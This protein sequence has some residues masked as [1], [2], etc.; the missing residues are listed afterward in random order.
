[1]KHAFEAVVVVLSFAIIAFYNLQ[2]TGQQVAGAQINPAVLQ[3]PVMTFN[4]Q[5]S[6]DVIF[7]WQR[8]SSVEEQWLDIS[9]FDNN[10]ADGTFLTANRPPNPASV[11]YRT[12]T[13]DIG[14]LIVCTRHYWRINT[15]IDGNW[16]PSLT[17]I[18]DTPCKCGRPCALGDGVGMH[19]IDDNCIGIKEFYDERMCCI[20]EDCSDNLCYQGVCVLDMLSSIKLSWPVDSRDVECFGWQF[21]TVKAGDWAFNNGMDIKTSEGTEVRAMHTGTVVSIGD[22]LQAIGGYG[23]YAMIEDR[24]G[25]FYTLYAHLRCGGIMVSI[26]DTVGQGDVIALSGGKDGCRGSAESEKLHIEVRY[27]KDEKESSVNP[28]VVLDGCS[29]GTDCR[30]YSDKDN[31][32]RCKGP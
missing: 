13:G 28:C 14:P 22:Y 9:I 31:P 7:S 32:E 8:A 3:K 1:M 27:R 10:F 21:D 23:N 15:L 11:S 6:I 17:G 20:G 30:L 18:F 5:G 2:P 16:Y 29:C 12:G 25:N 26:G 4:T 19:D 24:S